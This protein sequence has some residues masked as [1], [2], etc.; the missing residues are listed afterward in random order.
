M[1]F[2]NTVIPDVI[3]KP[4]SQA[5]LISCTTNAF[6]MPSGADNGFILTSDSQGNGTWQNNFKVG[7]QLYY[8]PLSSPTGTSSTSQ[9]MMGMGALGTNPWTYRPQASG[10]VLVM[11]QGY[12][13]NSGGSGTSAQLYYGTG[14]APANGASVVGSRMSAATAGVSP[15]DTN[16]WTTPVF[17]QGF[18]TLTVGVT[19]WFDVALTSGSA[20]YVG[21][22]FNPSIFLQEY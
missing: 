11:I 9:V 2:R 14:N 17:L 6:T 7:Q 20:S 12:I 10:K 13:G 4:W 16:G 15:N 3:D 8:Q 1:A 21:S 22:I 5:N 19:Y 18:A